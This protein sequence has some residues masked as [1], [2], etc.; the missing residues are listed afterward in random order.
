[1]KSLS[2][3]CVSVLAAIVMVVVPCSVQAST[4]TVP[5]TTPIPLTATDWPPPPESLAFQE[6]DPSLGTLNSVTLDLSGTLTT[7]LTVGNLSGSFGA[8]AALSSGS[9]STQTTLT[10]QD[11]LGN[12]SLLNL[13]ASFPFTN[14]SPTSGS[15]TITS[16][17]LMQTGSNGSTY[18]SPAVLA[19]FT[20]LSTISLSS[21]TSTLTGV[22]YT[23]GTAAA[24]ASQ[25][26]MAALT[27]S[28]TYNYTP[29]VVPE[30][31]TFALL[32]VGVWGIIGYRWRKKRSA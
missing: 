17:A 16:G 6:F 5:T 2:L 22:L 13:T 29:A 4:L 31:S 1:M 30:P 24:Y 9:A 8:G 19:E 23:G 7:T 12:E 28:V 18:V 21:S 20:G 32:T 15:N 3:F 10:V 11:P 14:L 27:G 25:A 26:P